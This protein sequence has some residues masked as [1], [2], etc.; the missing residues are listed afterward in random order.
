VKV[1]IVCA[2]GMLS[3]KEI[4]SVT[5]ARELRARGWEIEFVTSRWG[6]LEFHDLLDAESFTYHQLWLGFIAA[7]LK[8]APLAMTVDQLR[9][10]PSLV[11]G[12]RRILAWRKPDIVIHTNWHHALLLASFLQPS[13]D[14]YWSHELLPPT[15]PYR[16]VFGMIAR[17]VARMVC[18]SRAGA[19]SLKAL[20]IEDAKLAVVNNGVAFDA[21]PPPPKPA[22][23]LR[24]GIVGQIAPWKGHEDV[25]AALAILR[26]AGKEA[27]LTIFGRGEPGFV[28]TLQAQAASLGVADRIRLGGFVSR[29]SDIYEAI[30]VCVVPSRFEEPFATSALE[31]ALFGR[32]VIAAAVGGLPEI[33]EDHETGLLVRPACP[34]SL[35]QAICAFVRSPDM[36]VSMGRTARLRAQDRFSASRFG[37]TFA[38]LIEG[39]VGART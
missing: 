12:Y 39:V 19:G 27:T 5:L 9:R 20:G 1:L 25:V 4:V 24:L 36:V 2:G 35:A 18:V 7:T 32:P 22:K 28:E 30:D 23:P 15:A 17:R 8:W 21:E 3:G 10:W 38:E 6:A 34:D 29:K 16:A 13:R 11:L 37:R 33:V 26:T 31:A 14:I